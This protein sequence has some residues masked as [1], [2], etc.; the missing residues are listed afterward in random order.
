M[1][2]STILLLLLFP[3]FMA[4]GQALFK[5]AALTLPEASTI[6]GMLLGLA[7]NIWLLIALSIYMTATIMWVYLLRSVPLSV[8]FPFTA[9]SF[10]I[11]PLFAFTMY[12]E[13]I[14]PLYMLG[15]ALVIAGLVVIVYASGQNS[16]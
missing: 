2:L 10:V 5:K 14:R 7:T 15:I 6:G 13:P 12:G 4:T 16:A 9:L 11:V 8:A 1:S 3:I